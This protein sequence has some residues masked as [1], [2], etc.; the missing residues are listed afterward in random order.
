LERKRAEQPLRLLAD[1][2]E[3]LGLSLDPEAILR[4]LARIAV[5]RLADWCILERVEAGG[6]IRQV[7]AVHADAASQE[8][9]RELGRDYPTDPR[10]ELGAANVLR[11]RK[12]ELFPALPVNLLESFAQDQRHLE[13]LRNLDFQSSLAVPLEAEGKAHAVMTLGYSGSGRRPDSAAL[14]LADELARRAASLLRNAL[15]H[16]RICQAARRK[17]AFLEVLAHE[18]RDPLAPVGSALEMLRVQTD[19]DS[20]LNW[21]LR[22]LARQLQ[23]LA[24]LADDLLDDSRA[25]SGVMDLRTQTVDLAEVVDSAIDATQPLIEARNQRLLLSLGARPLSAEAD[26]ARMQQII[27]R[28]IGHAARRTESGGRIWLDAGREGTELVLRVRDS[29]PPLHAVWAPDSLA[30]QDE[31]DADVGLSLVRSLVEAQNGSLS[32]DPQSSERIVRLP[33][34]ELEAADE[35]GTESS[36]ETPSG[37]RVLVVDDNVDSATGMGQVLELWGY[38]AQIAYNGQEAIERAMSLRPDVVLLDIGL[39]GMSGYEIARVLRDQPDLARVHLVALTGFRGEE[40]VRRGREAGFHQYFTKPV[41]LNELRQYLAARPRA[42][43][44]D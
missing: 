35:P 1:A 25:A 9:M 8:L 17:D 14:E 20:E 32:I 40:D 3:L 10:A 43:R 28:L 21:P 22:L 37:L 29:G 34:P 18:L 2:G 24:Q 13:L 23:H 41:D 6:R 42:D 36:A 7:E 4:A 5:P 16:R 31:L 19:A 15:V 38:E 26:P 33:A 12:P 27:A 39:P 11:T 44:G 30:D